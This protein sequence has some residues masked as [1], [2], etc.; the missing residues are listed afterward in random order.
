MTTKTPYQLLKDGI[1]GQIISWAAGGGVTAVGP[2]TSGQ[3]LTSNGAGSAPSFQTLPGGGDMLLAGVQTVTGAKTFNDSTLLLGGSTSGTT[4]LNASAVAAGVLT[5]PATTDTLIARD[6][7]DTLTNKSI[8]AGSNTLTGL[9]WDTNMFADGTD[10]EIPTFDSNGEPAFVA[11]G[12]AGQVLTSNGAGAAPT[13]Q[14]ASS[15]ISDVVDDTTPQLGGNLDV[16]G[17]NIVSVSNANINILPNGTGNVALGNMLFDADQSIGAGQDDYVL[18]YDNGTGLISLEAAPGGGGGSGWTYESVVNTTSGDNITIASGLPAG[19][20]E[21]D[22]IFIGTATNFGNNRLLVQLGDSGGIE[23]SGYTGNYTEIDGSEILQNVTNAFGIWAPNSGGGGATYGMLR[24]ALT[25]TNTEWVGQGSFRVG[26][27]QQCLTVG[28]KNLS[29]VLTQIRL[30]HV[31]TGAGNFS[32][33]QV[34][35]RHR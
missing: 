33:G 11:A 34:V 28:H 32:T 16:N 17:N 35:V 2:G 1:A 8:D 7:T 6:T 9:V 20:E 31:N 14:A 19:V 21:V 24:L 5:L 30:T 27:T 10:G 18:T 26:A 29:S 22:I 4:G 23:T 13:F 15:G 12:T 25:D 3:V